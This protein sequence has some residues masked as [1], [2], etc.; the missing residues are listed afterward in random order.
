MSAVN[1]N[2]KRVSLLQTIGLIIVCYLLYTG[3]AIHQQSERTELIAAIWWH[4][5]ISIV[6]AVVLLT[7]F[8]GSKAV[9]GSAANKVSH[10]SSQSWQL[11]TVYALLVLLL[12]TGW[13]T[14]WSRGS[15]LK[16][17]D[18]FSLPSPVSKM[19][20]LYA[21]MESVHSALAILLIVM[22]SFSLSTLLY[23]RLRSF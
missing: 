13:L 15:A 8:V 11:I 12:A 19:P 18:W 4:V 10:W 17:F 9:S 2:I 5:G 1:I 14:V 21:L 3:F 6:A 20:Q 7:V 22:L 16:V 23:R